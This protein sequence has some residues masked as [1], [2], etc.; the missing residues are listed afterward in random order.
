MTEDTSGAEETWWEIYRRKREKE[1]A[2]LTTLSKLSTMQYSMR[3]TQ[4]TSG[5]INQFPKLSVESFSQL[6]ELCS[7]APLGKKDKT[8]VD[9][10]LR[11]TLQTDKVTIV[12]DE[13]PSVLNQIKRKFKIQNNI[14]AEFYKLLIYFFILFCLPIVL[15]FFLCSHI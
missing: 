7:P 11:K 8:V 1:N 15:I 4:F 12:W 2:V 10:D 14:R 9:E 13:L 3:N 6:K 5:K